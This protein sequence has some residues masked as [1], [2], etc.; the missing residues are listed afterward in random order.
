MITGRSSAVDGG[1]LARGLF[2]EVAIV[3]GTVFR[4]MLSSCLRATIYVVPIEVAGVASTKGIIT[5]GFSV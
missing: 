4:G 5:D 3:Y 1:L 2:T